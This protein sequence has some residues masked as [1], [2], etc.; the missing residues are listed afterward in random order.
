[1]WRGG[2]TDVRAVA[3]D[4]GIVSVVP[5]RGGV[6]A[7]N[8]AAPAMRVLRLDVVE[9]GAGKGHPPGQ[10]RVVVRRNGRESRSACSPLA[11]RLVLMS[12]FPL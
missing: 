10:R 3:H 6:T 11:R 4:A 9:R 5:A 8:R 7:A 1:L 2:L 12:V